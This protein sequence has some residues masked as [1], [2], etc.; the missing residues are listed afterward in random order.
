M[1]NKSMKYNVGQRMSFSR[2]VF[3]CCLKIGKIVVASVLPF[4]LK[5]VVVLTFAY[6]AA[7]VINIGIEKQE[8]VACN[9]LKAY[10]QTYSPHVFF[11]TVSEKAMCDGHGVYIDAPVK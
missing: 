5:V 6:I 7:H 11:I 4:V 1:K 9:Q 2:W 10:S 3:L 8:L